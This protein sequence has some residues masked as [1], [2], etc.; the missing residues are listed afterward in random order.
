MY[1]NLRTVDGDSNHFVVRRTLPLTDEQANLV[2]IIS[3]DD[4]VLAEYAER[5]Y[6]LT[7]TQLRIY[8]SDR[9]EVRIAYARGRER[10]SLHRAGDR[11]DLVAPVP[12][13]REKLLLFRAV[14]LESTERC[15]PMFGPAR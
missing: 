6:A 7:W 2:R 3:T 1:A 9:P 13:W 14:D 15:V 10:V 4:P 11:P 5:G 12:V 8:L